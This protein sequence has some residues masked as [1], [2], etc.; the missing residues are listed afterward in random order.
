M[1][2]FFRKTAPIIAILLISGLVFFGYIHATK[3]LKSFL[4]RFSEENFNTELSIGYIG[5]G[6]PVCLVLKDVRVNDSVNIH[7]VRF[8]PNPASF[9]LKNS[10]NFYCT[11]IDIQSNILMHDE[12]EKNQL[13]FV[14]VKGTLKGSGIYLSKDSVF[15]FTAK[16]FLKNRNT[17]FLSPIK[18]NGLVD[19]RDAIK[20]RLKA[21]DIKLETFSAIYAK[22]LSRGLKDGRID[23][24]SDIQIS[25]NNLTAKCFLKGENIKLKK[26][27]E[28]KTDMPF[29]AS[30]ILFVNFKDNLVKIKNL[31]GNFVKLI[32]G[33]S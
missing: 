25:K 24:E 28:Q 32:F 20:A 18:I 6:F 11:K 10:F 27:I 29:V 22:Y 26:G 7:S 17:D 19:P 2:N 31:Q 5:F 8:Y 9:L 16:G 12:R 15:R 3:N 23:F 33:R 13:E 21:N 14:K 4:L 1:G 30:F